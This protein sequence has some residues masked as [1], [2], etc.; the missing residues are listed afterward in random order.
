[1]RRQIRLSLYRAYQS[2]YLDRKL[3]QRCFVMRVGH[4]LN[5]YSSNAALSVAEGSHLYLNT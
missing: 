4:D 1:M 2:T 5:S 3:I